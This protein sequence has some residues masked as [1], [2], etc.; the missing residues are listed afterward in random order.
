[1]RSVAFNKG[2]EEATRKLNGLRRDFKRVGK[3]VRS[4]G[5]GL[6]VSLT[7]AVAAI[8]GLSVASSRAMG[9]LGNLARI[10]G[11]QAGKFKTLSIASGEF[12]IGQEKLA[13]IL[14]DVNDKFGDY[15]QTGAGPLAD[16]FE[17][18]APKVGLA[19]DAFRGLSSDDALALYVKSLEDANLSQ[20]DMTFYM[21]ALASDATALLPVFSQGAKALDEV[22]MKAEE[23]GLALSDETIA[24][25]QDAR[26]EFGI[27]SEVLKTQLQTSL[28]GLLPAFSN[29]AKAIVPF[30]QSMI[31]AVTRLSDGFQGLSPALQSLVGVG[32]LV[33]AALGP[34]LVVAGGLIA[35]LGAV[36]PVV[37]SLAVP[38][39]AL[40]AVSG[41]VVAA[42]GPLTQAVDFLRNNIIL[43]SPI[44]GQLV[45]ALTSSLVPALTSAVSGF[46]GLAAA[47]G[48]RLVAALRFA[49]AG[50][51]TFRGAL[52]S[53]GIG[54]LVVGIGFAIQKFMKLVDAAGGVGNALVALKAISAEVWGRVGLAVDA[55]GYRIAASAAGI[56]ASIVEA[57]GA[58][59]SQLPGFV[60]PIIGAYVGA[61]HSMKAIWSQLPNVMSNVVA[62]AAN[63]VL[64]GIEKMINFARDAMWDFVSGA[65]NL[66]SNIPG[67]EIN[68]EPLD[69]V[70]L[71]RVEAQATSVSNDVQAAFSEAFSR[72]YTGDLA[73]GLED[74]GQSA[75]MASDELGAMAD[76]YQDSVLKP[77]QTVEALAEAQRMLARTVGETGEELNV[78]TK[79]AGGL[80]VALTD[81]GSAGEG[82]GSRAGSGARRA[83]SELANVTDAA[84]EL[85]DELGNVFKDFLKDLSAGGVGDAFS[86]LFDR[87][88]NKAATSF[89]GMVSDAFKQGG[90]GI[91]AI[92]GGLKTSWA[93]IKSGIGSIFGG[94]GLSGIFGG[95]GGV[96]SS[97][98]PIIG[99]VSAVVNIIKG[100][101]SKKVI[102]GGINLGIEGGEILGGTF[103][104]IE[105]KKFW[106]LSKKRYD[107]NA[108]FDDEN[109][110]A[111]QAQVDTVQGSIKTIYGSLGVAVSDATLDAVNLAIQRIDTKGLSEEQI[112]EKIQEVFEKYGDALSVA[113]GG[114]G[115]E[116][117]A[118]LAQVQGLLEPLGK[119]FDIFGS[120]GA[121][122]S[123]N[124]LEASANAAQALTDMAGG[125][126]ALGQKTSAFYD[127]FFTEQEKLASI[128][129]QVDAT[130]AQMGL[131]IPATDDAF[132]QLVLS[133]DLMT[134]AGREAYNSLLD[135]APQFDAL[136]DAAQD[137]A[138]A[139]AEAAEAERDLIAS[140]RD[141]RRDALFDLLGDPQQ[142]NVLRNRI[143]SVFDDL[144]LDAPDTLG[145]LRS[146][147]RGL[148]LSTETGRAAW[149]AISA[150]VPDFERI[151]EARED[152]AEAQREALADLRA[153]RKDA[154]FDLLPEEKQLQILKKRV[155]DTFA[156][157]GLGIPKTSAGLAKVLG[158][159]NLTTDVGKSAYEAIKAI[160]PAF[161]KLQDVAGA[162]RDAV[163]DMRGEY[164][165]DASRY[166]TEFEAKLAHELGNQD[167]YASDVIDAQNTELRRQSALLDRVVGLLTKQNKLSGDS[168]LLAGMA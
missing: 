132:K 168:L 149:G 110:K 59:V 35:S 37:V 14:K 94:G 143:A 33:A 113:V 107:Q 81:A 18:I 44:I 116:L 42:W 162:F 112:E 130:F 136:T 102:G 144:G 151:I 141:D 111:L 103:K 160:I 167:Q 161:E 12:G 163:A 117:S 56:K 82:L 92:W 76:S 46:V 16:F 127:R 84:K 29:L 40:A 95:I 108:A 58:V 85:R 131:S 86:S 135:I 7:A 158:G 74:L 104:R 98:M 26:R 62:S 60:N 79:E 20:Q 28:A 106:G 54:A 142:L 47:M 154:V 118:S 49:T 105:K 2:V 67:V 17:N 38:M 34:V 64:S 119:A 140:M 19:A 48:T 90:G 87:L 148:D 72:D 65:A 146:V 124:L 165:L 32:A 22:R 6:T 31:A 88:K 70:Q 122:L 125:M 96:I 101:S 10:A 109:A 55:A 11:M 21:E 138:D 166:A 4:I 25:A 155:R 5:E 73:S 53:T 120:D 80:E 39:A 133:Q 13:D 15:F 83:V 30:A 1:M 69:R 43:L 27:V 97:A 77:L 93:G 115:F 137:A 150:I 126:E 75:R 3:Q 50:L 99:A 157:L 61:F 36:V 78:T 51:V 91:G 63:L 66:I 41:V 23:L 139:V 9:E 121:T 8:G 129:A 147:I 128:Q 71:K 134:E 52:I 123:E 159:L 45:I 24:A 164:S 57:F 100:F 153:D 145:G 152:A 89:S 156:D 114:I 68:V